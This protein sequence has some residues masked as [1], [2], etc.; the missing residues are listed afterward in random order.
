MA[1]V[2]FDRFAAEA[3]PAAAW[4]DRLAREGKLGTSTV[5]DIV[6]GPDR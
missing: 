6:L 4:R 5:R 3:D 2:G 1:D